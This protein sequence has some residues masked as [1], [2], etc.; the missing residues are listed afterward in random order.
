MDQKNKTVVLAA[1]AI[2]AVAL[3]AVNF[4]KITGQAVS[5]PL[6]IS[7][8]PP[9]V[10]AG[11]QI[12]VRVN[13]NGNRVKNQLE[14]R[15]VGGTEIRK[16]QFDKEHCTGSWCTKSKMGSSLVATCRTSPTWRGGYYVEALEYQSNEELGRA[17]FTVT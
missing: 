8:N 17:Y 5:G 11:Q 7:V 1:V 13:A 9:A 2:L 10:S 12:T 15:K 6:G 3:V 4:D 14:I 16:C